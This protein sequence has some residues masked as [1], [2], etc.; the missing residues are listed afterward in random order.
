MTRAV[1]GTADPPPGTPDAFE[2]RRLGIALIG[3]GEVGRIF[4][5]ALGAAGLR[6]VSA[7]DVLGTDAH[8]ATD[9]RGRAARDG[10]ALSSTCAA[11]VGGADL[12]ISAVTAASTVAAAARGR[13]RGPAAGRSPACAAW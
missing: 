7:F 12:V 10:V 13:R 9:A 2:R 4:G 1:A 6:G 5:G 11:A 8:W 3:Y